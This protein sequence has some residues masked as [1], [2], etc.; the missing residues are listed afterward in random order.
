MY[1]TA[2]A[3]SSL[4]WSHFGV[5]IGAP[6]RTGCSRMENPVPMCGGVAA[7]GHSWPSLHWWLSLT[8]TDQAT[9]FAGVGALCAALVA[10]G[11]ALSDGSRRRKERNARA[12]LTMASLYT[13]MSGVLAMVQGIAKDAAIAL[14]ARPG[15]DVL[16][17]ERNL[18]GMKDGCNIM[19]P[20]LKA[21]DPSEA[22]H[23]KADHGAALAAGISDARLLR[24][25]IANVADAYQIAKVAG[26]FNG[27]Y[28][29]IR[30]LVQA[31]SMAKA[32][33][34]RISPFIQACEDELGELEKGEEQALG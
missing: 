10:L 31:P 29:A 32:I 9:W 5:T 14:Q 1:P 19:K 4:Q 15:K 34:T 8:S 33:E 17:V 24:K 12:R 7:L 16:R 11:I 28:R 20:L 13:P 30:L 27:M 25:V 3:P 22:I 18:A 6:N 2:A 21:F 23:L 26:D